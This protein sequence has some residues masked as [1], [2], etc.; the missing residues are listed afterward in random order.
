MIEVPANE[1]NPAAQ[2]ELERA[3]AAFNKPALQGFVTKPLALGK[4]DNDEQ[5]PTE[6]DE[7]QQPETEESEQPSVEATEGQEELTEENESEVSEGF[8]AEFEKTFGLKPDEA[9]NLFNQLQAFRDEQVL[10]R[11]WKVDPTTYDERMAAVREF[12]SKLPEDGQQ[13]FNNIE[14]AKAIWQHLV[15]SGKVAQKKSPTNVKSARVNKPTAAKKAPPVL[16]KS[17]I[18]SMP[19]DEYKRRLPE[20]NKAYREKRVLNDV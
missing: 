19:E 2:A 6:V 12:Y 15:D 11:E 1:T 20:I 13:Q 8:S 5:V 7:V 3:M 10:M 14:G 9:V 4:E 16:K 18:L 17:E